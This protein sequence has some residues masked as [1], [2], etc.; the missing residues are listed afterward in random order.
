MVKL[1]CVLDTSAAI[2]LGATGKFSLAT[3]F[4][5]FISPNKVKD[6][7]SEISKTSDKIGEIASSLLKSG[8]VEFVTLEKKRQHA[9]GEIEAI[10]LGNKLKSDLILMDDIQATK[11]LQKNTKVPIKFSPFVIFVL[12]EKNVLSRN[13]A[14]S[15]IESMRIARDWKDNLIISYAYVLFEESSR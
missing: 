7:L 5:S 9:K 8:H 10:N 12:F 14:L 1:N 6:E 3:K 2:S 13:E 11:K 4:F 15:S